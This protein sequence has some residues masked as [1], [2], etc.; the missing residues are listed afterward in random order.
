MQEEINVREKALRE[1]RKQVENALT[2]VKLM[3]ANQEEQRL[4][5]EAC[6]VLP[7]LPMCL[8]SDW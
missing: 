6:R 1:A 4:E 5:L 8:N 7:Q 2:E 3:V